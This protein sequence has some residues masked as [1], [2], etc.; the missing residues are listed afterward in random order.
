MEQQ[1]EYPTPRE[2]RA[3]RLRVRGSD[4]VLSL[5]VDLCLVCPTDLPGVTPTDTRDVL[6]GGRASTVKTEKRSV[7]LPRSTV[8][9]RSRSGLRSTSSGF[10][11]RPPVTRRLA[12]PDPERVEVHYHRAPGGRWEL[13]P[14]ATEASVHSESRGV[15][16]LPSTWSE[17][18]V[19]TVLPDGVRPP[20]D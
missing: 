9:G 18:R 14:D 15:R 17:R 12:P 1:G 19:G 5:P 10:W 4:G 13:T 16:R 3:L 7:D 20:Q 2:R 11:G 6:W 8:S